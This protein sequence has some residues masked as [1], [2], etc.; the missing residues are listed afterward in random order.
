MEDQRNQ[1]EQNTGQTQ[2]GESG[3]QRSSGGSTT[4]GQAGGRVPE[5]GAESKVEDASGTD[6]REVEWRLDASELEPIE[7]WLSSS[8]GYPAGAPGDTGPRIKVLSGETKNLT[9][10]YYDTADWM[11]YRA[12]YALRIRQR[13]KSAEATMKAVSPDSSS[14]GEVQR[15]REIS[16]SLDNGELSTLRKSDGKVG[17]RLGLLVGSKDLE[18][19][20]EVRTHRRA[21]ELR[22]EAPE[23]S[24]EGSNGS[25]GSVE[26]TEP[27]ETRVVGEVALD[28]SEIPLGRGEEPARL[29]RVEVEV[30]PEAVTGELRRFVEELR[31]AHGLSPTKTSKYETGLYATG[32]VPEEGPELGPTRVDSSMTTGEVAFAVLRRQFASFVGREPGVRLGEDPEEVHDM[33]V[34]SRR[35][36]AAIKLFSE[37]LPGRS[38]WLEGELRWIAGELGGVRDLDVELAE[39]RA[40]TEGERSDSGDTDSL[41]ALISAVEEQRKEARKKMLEALDSGRYGRLK[42][43]FS[44]MLRRG[45]AG[46]GEKGS[47]AG[48]PITRAAP[49]LLSRRYKKF[50]RVADRVGSGKEDAPV[51]AYHE[52]RKKGKSLRY[53]LEF[54]REIYGSAVKDVIRPLK[55]LQDSLGRHQDAVVASEQLRSLGT[56]TESNL[57]SGT[58]FAMGAYAERYRREAAELRA[59]IP[60]SKAFRTLRNRS[61]QKDLEKKLDESSKKNKK[62]GKNKKS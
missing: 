26:S 40:W 57:S 14:G 8:G 3:E 43:S 20:F 59:G 17:E 33:R 55:S 31:S 56:E 28:E 39:L 22:L 45:S 46:S 50:R 5:P 2:P 6:A 13:G 29:R 48:T 41:G 52:L 19:I 54:H 51:E 35:L 34:A 62:N 61:T 10:A 12:G 15:R 49:A 1:Q 44:D 18:E 16:E 36:R 38:G 60:N 37:A 9:D 25:T 47:K 30:F 53:A 4:E 23:D 32:L 24:G 21:F 27:A 7:E 11:L 42:D 58:V